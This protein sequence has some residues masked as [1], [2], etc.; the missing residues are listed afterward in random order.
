[1]ILRSPAALISAAILHWDVDITEDK[2][3]V[4][5]LGAKD[6]LRL[7]TWLVAWL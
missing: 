7:N 4:L 1:M 2:P 3:G 5:A 6:A